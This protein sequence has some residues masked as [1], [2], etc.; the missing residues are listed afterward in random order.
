MRDQF[1]SLSLDLSSL[2]VLNRQFIHW[3]EEHYNA[4][5]HSVLE[6]TPLDRFA[7]DRSRVRYLPPNQANDELFFVEEDRTVRADNTF[8]FKSVRFEA[9]RHLPDRTI[10]I[11]FERK[12]PTQRVIVYYKAERMGEARPLDP[13][14]NDRK[15]SSEKLNPTTQENQS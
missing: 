11:R 3:V 7:L 9:P 6:M 12:R 14:A 4:Q 1:L 5:K 2:D 15:P 13:V 10:Q 8:S